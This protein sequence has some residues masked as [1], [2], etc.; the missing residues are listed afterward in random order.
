MGGPEVHKIK[1]WIL[2]N[3]LVNICVYYK[4]VFFLKAFVRTQEIRENSTLTEIVLT[5]LKPYTYYTIK[6]AIE[7]H[8][9]G[10]FIG[11]AAGIGPN[12]LFFQAIL[13]QF[14][15]NRIRRIHAIYLTNIPSI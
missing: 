14:S 10:N 5:G 4:C 15:H 7:L 8:E 12:L 1:F 2:Y 3:A 13:N 9:G 11:V 6:L